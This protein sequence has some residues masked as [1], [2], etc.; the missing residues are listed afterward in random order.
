M[1]RSHFVLL[2][3]AAPMGY[4]LG[5]AAV[6]F[7]QLVSQEVTW[8][9]IRSTGFAAYFLLTLT[10][11]WG[12]AWKTLARSWLSTL[13]HSSWHRY[14]S[15]WGGILMLLHVILLLFDQKVG[16]G[17]A[18]VLI[19]GLSAYR[20]QAVA[21]GVVALYPLALT[22]FGYYIKNLVKSNWWSIMHRMVPIA[23]ALVT[24]HG[25]WA[26]TDTDQP[27]ARTIYLAGVALVS[28]FGILRLLAYQGDPQKLKV[29]EEQAQR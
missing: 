10:T 11:A 2:L 19:P 15:V 6:L 12:F 8:L 14:L 5:T 23:W 25:I 1:T 21:L 9:L 29:S 24:I 16:F 28:F 22:I 3:L 26:G 7:S 18:E 20:P 17:V 4:V 13:A 27:W